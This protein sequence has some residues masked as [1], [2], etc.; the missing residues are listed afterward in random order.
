MNGDRIEI[1]YCNPRAGYVT[2]SFTDTNVQA[3]I[4]SIKA[5]AGNDVTISIV[6]SFSA[7]APTRSSS[8]RTDEHGR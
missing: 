4:S 3:A 5:R 1:R 8:D 6:K 2:E 7:P